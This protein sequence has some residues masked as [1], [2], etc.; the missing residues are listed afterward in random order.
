VYG[1]RLDEATY[2]PALAV[3]CR[4]RFAELTGETKYAGEVGSLVAPYQSGQ[5][6]AK[7]DSHVA[8][9]GHLA[10]VGPNEHLFG[11]QIASAANSVPAPKPQEMSDA[12]FMCGPI[13]GEA[14]RLT[15]DN[16]H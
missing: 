5:K 4:G 10:F 3:Y 16:K 15:K 6:L 2:I 7:T 13:V 9:A 8:L 11:K 1:K 14:G 12:V